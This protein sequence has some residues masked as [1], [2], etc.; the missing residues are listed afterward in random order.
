MK[1]LF[2]ALSAFACFGMVMEGCGSVGDEGFVSSALDQGY[3]DDSSATDQYAPK[4]R[5]SRSSAKRAGKAKRSTRKARTTTRKAKRVTKP[6][7][8]SSRRKSSRVTK[9]SR[10]SSKKVRRRKARI[11]KRIRRVRV[12]D[13]RRTRVIVIAARPSGISRD[14]GTISTRQAYDYFL[15]DQVNDR[16]GFLDVR[17]EEDYKAGHIKDAANI[18]F[19]QDDPSYGEETIYEVDMEDGYGIDEYEK[20][21]DVMDLLDKD[22]LYVVYCQDGSVSSDVVNLMKGW[23]FRRA[24]SVQGGYS[25]WVSAGYPTVTGE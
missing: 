10:K 25:G 7:K 3:D 5:G 16:I 9:R 8:Q 13:R 15:K 21:K 12:T 18:E 6:R 24:Y 20:F 22:H 4:K 17:S 1:K 19:L 11:S 2:I 23:S 14:F